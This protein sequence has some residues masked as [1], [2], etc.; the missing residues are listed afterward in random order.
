M[1]SEASVACAGA[2]AAAGDRAPG[3]GAAPSCDRAA[4]ETMLGSLQGGSK[5]AVL[6]HASAWLELIY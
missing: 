3:T 2:A 5:G 6:C 1:E 4:R